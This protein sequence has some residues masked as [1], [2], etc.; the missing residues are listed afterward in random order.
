MVWVRVA[1]DTK[2]QPRVDPDQGLHALGPGQPV[3]RT[4]GLV[5]TR[6]QTKGSIPII[7]C[8]D[9]DSHLR[10]Q[11]QNAQKVGPRKQP[12]PATRSWLLS[13]TRFQG[14]ADAEH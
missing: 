4:E 1:P 8:C 6:T 5:Q 9:S 11:R 10:G 13:R 2:F 14:I 3:A 12:G 7:Y